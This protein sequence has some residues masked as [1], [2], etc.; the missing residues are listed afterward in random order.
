[1]YGPN[2]LPFVEAVGGGNQEEEEGAEDVVVL[3]QALDV[4]AHLVQHVQQ[5]HAAEDEGE[6]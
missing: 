5:Q 1:M 3:Q 6:Y 2:A 4:R